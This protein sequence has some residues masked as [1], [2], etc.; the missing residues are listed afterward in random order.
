MTDINYARLPE[1]MQEA[2]QDYI[3]AGIHPGGFLSAVL[4]NDFMEAVRR[5]D[6]TSRTALHAYGVFLY[7]EAPPACYGSPA[8][9]NAWIARDGLLG[10]GAA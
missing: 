1:H 4:S 3:E 8:K 5:A 9:F 10:E 6:D 7:C 2:M